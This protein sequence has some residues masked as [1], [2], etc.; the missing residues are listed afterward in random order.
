MFE[1]N[2]DELIIQNYSPIY[3]KGGKRMRMRR[4]SYKI[5]K[6]KRCKTNK[7]RSRRRYK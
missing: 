4:R 6:S 3:A 2:F 1:T 7:N 5:K